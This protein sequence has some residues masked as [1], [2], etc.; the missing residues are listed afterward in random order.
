MDTIITYQQ[1]LD[2]Y[3]SG[4]IFVHINKH[5]AGD[6]IMSDFA[7]KKYKYLHTIIV[8]SG[9]LITF[10]LTFISF[11]IN[12]KLAI[13]SFIFGVVIIGIS[14]NLS[15]KFVLSN[16]LAS[17]DFWDYILLHGGAK[18]TDGNGTELGSVFLHKMA[19]DK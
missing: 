9:I 5:K 16:M 7:S 19:N 13:L 11:F 17:Q 12:W 8:W 10:L 2:R 15:G 6:F 1:F 14:R 18:I 3:K 4:Q